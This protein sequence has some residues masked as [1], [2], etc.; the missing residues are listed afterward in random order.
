MKKTHVILALGLILASC[1]TSQKKENTPESGSSSE[2]AKTMA[3]LCPMDCEKGKKYNAPGS[4]P[5]C[6]MDLEAKQ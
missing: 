4:C 5:V 6:G 3:Y 1:S 2:N